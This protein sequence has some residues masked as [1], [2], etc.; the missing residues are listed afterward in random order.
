[1]MDFPLEKKQARYAGRHRRSYTIRIMGDDFVL[2]IAGGSKPGGSIPTQHPAAALLPDP[3]PAQYDVTIVE[4]G[5]LSRR[6]GALGLI[7]GHADFVI[8]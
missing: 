2:T 8:A 4:D 1:M 7:E 6:D 3:A 5:G